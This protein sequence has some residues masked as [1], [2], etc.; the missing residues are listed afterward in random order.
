MESP[1]RDFSLS[2][3]FILIY[4]KD[5][6]RARQKLKE[7]VKKYQKGVESDLF[8]NILMSES[9]SFQD[10]KNELRQAPMFRESQIVILRNAFLDPEFNNVTMF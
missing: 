10:F 1:A 3:M 9:L 7:I 6:F 5:A 2:L 8:L 4:G